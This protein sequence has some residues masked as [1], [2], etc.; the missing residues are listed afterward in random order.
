MNRSRATAQLTA[1][2]RNTRKEG[3]VMSQRRLISTIAAVFVTT[4]L[5]AGPAGAQ[6]PLD[7]TIDPTQGPAGT[8]ITGQ[9]DPADVAASCVTDLAEFQAEFT[10]LLNDVFDVDGNTTQTELFQRFFPG[11][12][13]FVFENCD[14]LAFSLTGLTSFGIAQNVNGAAETALP[15]TFVLTF[16]DLATQEPIG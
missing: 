9:V 10:V 11:Q 15:Q 16:A 8:V 6:A 13:D 5:A 14:Q 7:F 2:S 4:A 12:T 3:E 1:A